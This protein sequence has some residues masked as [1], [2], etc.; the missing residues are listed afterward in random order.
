MEI[1]FKNTELEAILEKHVKD[2]FASET[3][4]EMKNM[5]ITADVP[6]SS[7]DCTVTIEP[8]EDGDIS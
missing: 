6:Y 2:L 1:T 8:K 3:L 4:E 5:E 7:R